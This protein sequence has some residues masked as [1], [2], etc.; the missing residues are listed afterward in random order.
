MRRLATLGPGINSNLVSEAIFSNSLATEPIC[1][2]VF[3]T[4]EF[5]LMPQ[6]AIIESLI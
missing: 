4:L 5:S 1:D 2:F 6:A 3:S